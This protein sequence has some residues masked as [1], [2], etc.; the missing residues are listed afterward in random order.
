[1]FNSNPFKRFAGTAGVTPAMSAKREQTCAT[2]SRG[3][4]QK[5]EERGQARLPDPETPKLSRLL[6]VASRSR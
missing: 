3:F 5:A 1:M 2:A 4:A 6:H